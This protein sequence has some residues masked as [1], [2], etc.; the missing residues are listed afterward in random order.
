MSLDANKSPGS[1]KSVRA[2]VQLTSS[3]AAF[4]QCFAVF[5]QFGPAAGTAQYLD[6]SPLLERVNVRRCWCFTVKTLTV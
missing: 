2:A 5:V 6:S 3:I 1:L 4:G